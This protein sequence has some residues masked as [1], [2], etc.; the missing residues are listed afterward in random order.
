MADLSP[1]AQLVVARSQKG[2]G[3]KS[4]GNLAV[5]KNILEEP[6]GDRK[7]PIRLG[8]RFPPVAAHHISP[9]S[10]ILAEISGLLMEEKSRCA[11]MLG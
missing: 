10:T 9:P 2:L 8:T 5:K 7:P 4:W 6:G 1:V 3:T 11:P